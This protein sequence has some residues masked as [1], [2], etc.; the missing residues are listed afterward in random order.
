MDSENEFCEEDTVF[1]DD[2]I[3]ELGAEESCLPFFDIRENKIN[4]N[5]DLQLALHFLENPDQYKLA[6][7]QFSRYN[8]RTEGK[9]INR[10]V[11]SAIH[12]LFSEDVIDNKLCWQIGAGEFTAF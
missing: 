10:R 1:A 9:E 7:I 12:Q 4:G 8:V 2:L 11:F 6:Q 5:A 3:E